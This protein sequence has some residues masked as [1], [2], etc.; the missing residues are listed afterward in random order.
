MQVI[1]PNMEIL[2]VSDLSSRVTIVADEHAT[3]LHKL[4]VLRVSKCESL[5]AVFDLKWY[6]LWGEHAEMLGQ[7]KSMELSDL[8][9]LTHIWRNVPKGSQG[10]INLISLE[11]TSCDSMKYLLLPSMAKMVANLQELKLVGCERMEEVIEMEDEESFEVEMMDKMVIPQ[12]RILQLKDM[13]KLAIFWYGKRDFELPLLENVF[14]SNC[15]NMLTF[16]SGRL[17]A[18]NLARVQTH[19]LNLNQWV[20]KGDLNSTVIFLSERYTSLS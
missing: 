10:F 1:L 14:I 8:P 17:V 20:W 13:G 7:L 9:K 5:E 4:R 2:D 6:K 18:P 3:F 11:V 19:H 12:L 16:Y 15:P